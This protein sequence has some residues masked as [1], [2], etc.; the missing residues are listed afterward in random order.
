MPR[1]GRVALESLRVCRESS[2]FLVKK[3]GFFEREVFNGILFLPGETKG[4]EP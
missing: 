1:E 3:M 4:V 2:V